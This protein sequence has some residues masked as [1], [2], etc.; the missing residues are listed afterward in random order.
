MVSPDP[1]R[2]TRSDGVLRALIVVAKRPSVGKTKT[3][4]SPPLSGSEAA[5][6]YQCF[7]LDTLDLMRHVQDVQPVLAYLPYGSESFFRGIAPPGFDLVP[8][9]GDN[10]GQHLDNVLRSCLGLGYSQAVVMNSDG[11][12]LPVEYLA[13][14]FEKLNDPAVDVVLG[15]SEDGGYYL[16]GLKSPCSD[17]F[18]GITMSTH[19]VAQET[20]RRAEENSLGIS[21]LPSWHD[22]DT[23]RELEDL[24]AELSTLPDHIARRTR[25]FL[26]LL[27]ATAQLDRPSP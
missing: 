20:L 9:S 24:I 12:T 26:D 11:P 14:A 15:P 7:L 1:G 13:L 17:L 18:D 21:C 6:L 10:L 22:V 16:I 8:Q 23:P 3:R 4:L 27:Y 19:T 5:G 2:I 25:D